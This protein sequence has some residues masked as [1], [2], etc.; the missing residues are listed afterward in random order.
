MR[1]TELF[2]DAWSDANNAWHKQGQDDE[3]HGTD[4]QWHSSQGAGMVEDFAVANLVTTENVDVGDIWQARELIGAAMRD[5]KNER[6]RY[7]EFLKSLR[8]RQG[9]DYSTEVHRRA[10]DLVKKHKEKQ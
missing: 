4:D 1:V 3:W 10:A 9:V 6:H 7:F 2:D 5:P 8:D